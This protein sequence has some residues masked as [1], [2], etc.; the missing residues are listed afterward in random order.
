MLVGVEFVHVPGIGDGAEDVPSSP[1]AR[2]ASGEGH[3]G[4]LGRFAGSSDPRGDGAYFLASLVGEEDEAG[5]EPQP[6][7]RGVQPGMQ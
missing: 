7:G 6:I 1:E 2:L 3:R 4:K 5:F